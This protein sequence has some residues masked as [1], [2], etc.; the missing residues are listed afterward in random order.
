M[1]FCSV[2][3]RVLHN[4]VVAQFARQGVTYV[5]HVFVFAHQFEHVLGLVSGGRYGLLQFFESLLHVIHAKIKQQVECTVEQ[6]FVVNFL[7]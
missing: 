6:A 3:L 7:F 4:D 2:L 1:F 5:L